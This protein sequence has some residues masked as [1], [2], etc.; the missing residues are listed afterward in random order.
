MVYHGQKTQDMAIDH[1]KKMNAGLPLPKDKGEVDEYV[2]IT[3]R[4]KGND[5]STWIGLTDSTL[6]GEKT[7]WKDLNGNPSNYVNL[8]VMTFNFFSYFCVAI[9]PALS[10]HS[11][12]EA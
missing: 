3:G 2:K 12:E 4:G 5:K 6:S 9:D 11:M 8:R 1:C 10:G 7:A